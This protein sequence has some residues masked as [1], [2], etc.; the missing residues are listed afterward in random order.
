MK[1]RWVKLATSLYLQALSLFKIIDF[2]WPL[3][4]VYL[5]TSS[6]RRN[7]LISN[8][9]VLAHFALLFCDKFSH[10][11][12]WR[13]S[14][15][16]HQSH[17][18][19]YRIC[20]FHPGHGTGIHFVHRQASSWFICIWHLCEMLCCCFIRSMM[21]VSHASMNFLTTSPIW[22]LTRYLFRYIIKRVVNTALS[23]KRL[24][25]IDGD[26]VIEI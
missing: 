23:R 2:D 16:D 13:Q 12:R 9:C 20:A 11:S 24:L 21:F 18:G 15:D 25:L 22:Y 14:C 26:K 19:H 8:P 1:I 10:R 6:N 5:V 4:L 3:S 7:K 17:C